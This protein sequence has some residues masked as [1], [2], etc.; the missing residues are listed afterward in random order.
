[1]SEIG[2]HD[3]PDMEFKLYNQIQC[4]FCSL[5]IEFREDIVG[6]DVE[7]FKCKKKF[8]FDDGFIER[9][10]NTPVFLH[11]L[12]ATRLGLLQS[13]ETTLR[14]GESIRINFKKPFFK[15]SRV[16]LVDSEGHTY[17]TI[18]T[19]D[20]VV[21][22]VQVTN[23]GFLVVCS[24]KRNVDTEVPINWIASGAESNRP[25]PVWHI[26]L[27]NSL[28]LLAKAE[29]GAVMVM[30]MMTFDS[31]LHQLLSERLRIK[32]ALPQDLVNRIIMS[33]K[34]GRNEFLGYWL[35]SLFGKSFTKE[36]LYNDDLKEFANMRVAIVHPTQQGLDESKLTF[37]NAEKCIEIALKSI[38]WLSHLKLGLV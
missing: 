11:N 20:Y 3:F 4:P 10:A 13:G 31:Y 24:K 15:V 28:D 17:D 27:Q 22:C 5:M 6:K 23:E 21:A 29:Y 2:A 26:F 18:E 14:I 35:Q 32:H 38:Q 36:C 9:I 30:A 8:W 33:P 7:C 19:A 25:I 37:E 34:F 1:M 12:L 16:F